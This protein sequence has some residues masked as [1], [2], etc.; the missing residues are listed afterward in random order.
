METLV[1]QVVLKQDIQMIG[2]NVLSKPSLKMVPIQINGNQS[3][4]DLAE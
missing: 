4:K 2:L 3:M 1:A